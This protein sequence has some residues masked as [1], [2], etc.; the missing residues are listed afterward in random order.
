MA[1]FN[2]SEYSE[3]ARSYDGELLKQYLLAIL[4]FGFQIGCTKPDA[5]SNNIDQSVTDANLP[6]IAEKPA[7]SL[8]KDCFTKNG[9]ADQAQ[10]VIASMKPILDE[11]P[12]TIQYN[13]KD[14]AALNDDEKW[15]LNFEINSFSAPYLTLQGTGKLCGTEL[16]EDAISLMLCHE[17]GHIAGGT[18]Y[19]KFN[20][21]DIPFSKEASADFFATSV[22]MPALLK[23]QNNLSFTKLMTDEKIKRICKNEVTDSD[24][25]L[26]TRIVLASLNLAKKWYKT[27]ETFSEDKDPGPVPSLDSPLNV[28]YKIAVPW[29]VDDIHPKPQ[30]RLDTFLKGLECRSIEEIP[31]SLTKTLDIKTQCGISITSIIRPSCF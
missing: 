17:I 26:C 16:S 28:S 11:L 3:A 24:K 21:T 6:V 23:H 15:T 22:C 25:G 12:R 4:L 13:F 1:P 9:V 2:F 31:V 30:C 14:Y 18:P 7:S 10:L 29:I 19:R 5:S 27:Y 20:Y 8:P